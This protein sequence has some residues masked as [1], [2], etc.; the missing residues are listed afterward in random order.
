M[1][2]LDGKKLAKKIRKEVKDKIAELDYKPG[3]ITILV[4]EDPASKIYVNTKQKTAERLGMNSETVKLPEN[5]SEEELSEIITKLNK[6]DAVDAILV[7]SPLPKHINEPRML[8]MIT[9][10]KDVDCFTSENLGKLLTG[11][12]EIAP[13]TPAGIIELLK[14]YN[15]ET[16][17]KKATIIGRSTIVGMPMIPLMLGMNCT[18]TVCHS[19]TK[20]LKKEC[21]EADIIIVAVG[22]HHILTE[23]M[24]KDGA[25]VVDVGI[26]QIDDHIEGDV[27]FDNVLGKASYITP[28]PGGVGPMTIA[29]LMKNTLTLAQKRRNH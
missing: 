26:H 28:V 20:D 3:L 8:E 29:M 22:K 24:V 15:I 17:G 21:L 5:T 27:D 4:G 9:P 1:E 18:T 14:E 12:G 13:C 10:Q 23:E 19:R 25:V 11:T 16:E 6:D 7:Q 2:I